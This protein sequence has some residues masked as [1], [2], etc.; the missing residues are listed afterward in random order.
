MPEKLPGKPTVNHADA[1]RVGDQ[2]EDVVALHQ[3]LAE[4]G[5]P[6]PKLE[7]TGSYFG[8][9]TLGAVKDFQAK[10]C[11]TVDGVVGEKTWAAL[12]SLVDQGPATSPLLHLEHLSPFVAKL[13]SIADREYR[14]PVLEQPPGSNRGLYV[15][16]YLV[17]HRGD[18]IYLRDF[19]LQP[20]GVYFGAPWCFTGDV[21][22]LTEDGW[23]PFAVYDDRVR[24]AQVDPVSL[25]V[26][27]TTGVR[28]ERPYDG[29]LV[30]LDRRSLCM[31]MDPEHHL[32][33]RWK[34]TGR[35][36][37]AQN[38]PAYEKR[39]AGE[40]IR[41]DA[42]AVSIPCIAGTTATEAAISDRDLKLL[43]AFLADGSFSQYGRAQM[44]V[45]RD[46][47]L[48]AL[49]ALEPAS[50][51]RAPRAYG[52]SIEP[53][54]TFEFE[55]PACF[56]S[57]MP[58]YKELD[59]S[60][61]WRLSKRQAGLLLDQVCYFDGTIEGEHHRI[62]QSRKHLID[63]FHLLSVLAGYGA[64]TSESKSWSEFDPKSKQYCVSYEKAGRPFGIEREHASETAAPRGTMLYCA[65][66]P[67][68]LIVVRPRFGRATVIGNCG[69]FA[70]WCVEEAAMQLGVEAPTRG[71]DDLA[72]AA[73][74]RGRA[75]LAGCFSQEPA[76]GAIGCILAGTHGHVVLVGDVDPEGALT[77]IEGNSGGRVNIRTRKVEEF[78]GFVN[79]KEPGVG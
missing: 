37:I 65:S 24:I 34:K 51:Y 66:V 44:Q 20:N 38:W 43:G 48:E 49:A 76:P 59:S 70:L 56:A 53:L 78:A 40:L 23:I 10:H 54:T 58:R 12:Q 7:V 26:S 47:K 62:G 68:G 50:I 32:F 46:Y 27:L 42:T 61:M 3:A 35:K 57:A 74:W 28:I 77:C 19:N 71:W 39:A 21:E 30:T 1:L 17:G 60:W 55:V 4:R 67:S 31:T 5:L 11:L 45:S 52:R 63:S 16:M 8:P 6:A 72:S 73:K 69:R 14:K 13:L 15:D 33:G 25:A 29:P 22:V 64:Q 2:G 75:A 79:L 36:G 9:G 41:G 18:G